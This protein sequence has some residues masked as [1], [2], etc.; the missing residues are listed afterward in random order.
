MG[1]AHKNTTAFD[2]ISFVSRD[3]LMEYHALMGHN[4]SSLNPIKPVIS[5]NGE[6]AELLLGKTLFVY[7]PKLDSF[8]SSNK[9]DILITKSGAKV[10]EEAN[11]NN[12]PSNAKVKISKSDARDEAG[13]NAWEIKKG[14]KK[15]DNAPDVI[16]VDGVKIDKKMAQSMVQYMIQTAPRINE[17]VPRQSEINTRVKEAIKEEVKRGDNLQT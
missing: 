15:L 4:P 1:N 7:E 3:A 2:S 12:D 6:G 11:I 17:I 13:Y 8:F 10:F 5:S 16:K 9:V 14:L